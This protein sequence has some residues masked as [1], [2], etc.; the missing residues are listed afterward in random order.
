[1]SSAVVAPRFCISAPVSAV[2]EIGTFWRF[3]ARR[4]AVTTISVSSPAGAPCPSA[5]AAVP[6][7]I[8]KP[9]NSA[10]REAW[11]NSTPMRFPPIISIICTILPSISDQ[12]NP[13]E[14][15]NRFFVCRRRIREVEVLAETDAGNA[16]AARDV[17]DVTVQYSDNS[18]E[19][20]PRALGPHVRLEALGQTAG[21]RHHQ[22]LRGLANMAGEKGGSQDA[23]ALDGCPMEAPFASA[24]AAAE[25]I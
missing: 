15:N 9:A 13:L 20:A 12:I 25:S 5:A 18:V 8:A 23:I 22:A 11:L 17:V 19:P 3:S 7:I 24:T 1:M 4:C 10:R 14:E 16:G 6:T 21:I 2:T